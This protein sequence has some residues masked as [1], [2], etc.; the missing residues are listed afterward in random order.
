MNTVPTFFYEKPLPRISGVSKCGKISLSRF[1]V[2]SY[3]GAIDGSLDPMVKDP[4]SGKTRLSALPSS[5]VAQCHIKTTM[6]PEKSRK[7]PWRRSLWRTFR[8]RSWMRVR[9]SRPSA[10]IWVQKSRVLTVSSV[11][12]RSRLKKQHSMTNTLHREGRG[13][14]GS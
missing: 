5:K 11:W 2:W 1:P 8:W 10:A 6:V 9:R 7:L 12:S 4:L 14:K 3:G 13:K